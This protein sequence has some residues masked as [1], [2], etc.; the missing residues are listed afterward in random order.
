MRPR[1]TATVAR[2]LAMT[3]GVA[4]GC[5]ERE[6]TPASPPAG[7]RTA[8][9]A[10]QLA[11]PTGMVFVP[12]GV[13]H[14]GSDDGSADELPVFAA[15]VR[16]YFLDRHP[17]T[18]AQFRRFVGAAQHVTDAERLGDAGVLDAATGRWALVPGATW[19]HPLGPAGPPAPDD[20]PVTQVSWRDA[21]AYARWAGRRLPTEIEWEHAARGAVNSRSRYPWGDHLT[22]RGRARANTGE[23]APPDGARP[24]R[25][26]GQRPSA[27]DG[28]L[29]TSPVGAFGATRL[30][31]TDMGGNVW[32]WTSS[33]YRSYAER[34]DP[35]APA[36]VHE[37]VQRGGSFL[38][39]T[40][41]C[42]G[43]RVSARAHAT[44]ETA[45]FHVGFR[46]AADAP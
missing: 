34:D 21:V 39:S 19:H 17:V 45:L 41:F 11:T 23:F 29:L 30:G 20:H 32:E 22:E 13:V 42:H 27:H 16:G 43:F 2:A 46:T 38:C 3:L 8:T 7:G 25:A 9:P 12:G 31:L 26:P 6:H 14:V 5:R 35:V 40:S 1:R 33:W 24:S 15:R 44:P 18:V 37:R 36:R 28:H 4:L 10:R